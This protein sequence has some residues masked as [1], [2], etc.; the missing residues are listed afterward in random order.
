MRLLPALFIGRLGLLK[1]I[2][3]LMAT[4]FLHL[5]FS[6]EW[7]VLLWKFAI[8][9]R[10]AR[11]WDSLPFVCSLQFKVKYKPQPNP[12]LV[13]WSKPQPGFM[14]FNV[15]G[16]S[17]GNPR[18]AGGGGILCDHSGKLVRVFSNY[19][20]RILNMYSEDFALSDGLTMCVTFGYLNVIVVTDRL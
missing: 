9:T 5:L 12:I 8:F 6:L 20:G 3:F 14:K 11:I 2:F 4:Q 16:S 13:R 19:F 1:I 7:L 17:L 15:D 18:H 10:F